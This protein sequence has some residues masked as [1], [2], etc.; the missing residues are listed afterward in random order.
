[1]EVR[2]KHSLARMLR[3]RNVS[4][5]IFFPGIRILHIYNEISW[6]KDPMLSMKFI[7]IS[8]VLSMHGLKV[9]LYDI[10]SNLVQKKVFSGTKM[11]PEIVLHRSPSPLHFL[12]QAHTKPPSFL[13]WA[14]TYDS[15]VSVCQ[16]AR[17]TGICHH[18][19]YV[20]NSFMVWNFLLVALCWH[21]QSLDHGAFQI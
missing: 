9:I 3:T 2:V 13:G 4:G 20:W 8:C 12:R 17:I 10:F 15:P 18:T 7:S 5:F 1:M 19:G 21:S 16:S 6:G 11:N 14:W